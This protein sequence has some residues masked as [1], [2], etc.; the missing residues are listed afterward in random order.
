MSACTF[1]QIVKHQIP[2]NLLLENEYL[3]AILDVDPISDGHALIIPKPHLKGLFDLNEKMGSEIMKA[4]AVVGK[5][6][7]ETFQYDGI[8]NMQV[9]G[10]FQDIPHFHMHVFGRRKNED[11]EIKYPTGVNKS[12]E[13]LEQIK[14]RMKKHICL[15]S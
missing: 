3:I 14:L 8:M 2:A 15:N 7:L 4:A 1:C 5:C 13:Y 12:S 6:L 9:N 11:I 10:H